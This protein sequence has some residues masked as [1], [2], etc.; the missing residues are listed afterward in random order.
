MDWSARVALCCLAIAFPTAALSGTGSQF[1]SL[2][3]GG[4]ATCG[5]AVNGKLYCWGTAEGGITGKARIPASP[6]IVQDMRFQSVSVGDY[7]ACGIETTGHAYCWGLAMPKSKLVRISDALTFRS[8]SSGDWFACGATTNGTAYCWT[9]CA[10]EGSITGEPICSDMAAIEPVRIDTPANVKFESVSSGRAD[11]ACGVASD[12]AGYCWG[13]RGRFWGMGSLR[14]GG[15]ISFRTISAGRY[16]AFAVS[17]DGT[18]YTWNYEDL[19]PR[20]LGTPVRF[21]TV[22]ARGYF[23]CATDVVGAGY[24][25]GENKDNSSY[26]GTGSNEA[27]KMPLRLFGSLKF[28]AVTTGHFHACGLTT[29]GGAYCW[30]RDSEVGNGIG[31]SWSIPTP[32]ALVGVKPFDEQESRFVRRADEQEEDE[33]WEKRRSAE[34]ELKMK[35][36][37]VMIEAKSGEQLVGAGAGILFFVGLDRAYVVTAYHLIRPEQKLAVAIN[38]RFWSRP[39]QPIEA[40]VTGDWDR[41]LDLVVLRVDG[42]DRLGL[43]LYSLPFGHVRFDPLQKGASL[44]HLGNPGG[45]TW[46][47]NVKPDDFLENRRGVAYFESN[48][49]RPGVSGGALLDQQMNLI[50]MIRADESGEGAAVS[51]DV[52]EGR[53]RTW[54]YPVYL[55][56]PPAAPSFSSVAVQNDTF[57]GV[58]PDHT[59][60]WWLQLDNSITSIDGLRLDRIASGDSGGLNL[61]G[62]GTGGEAHCWEHMD[63]GGWRQGLG[64]RKSVP[65]GKKFRSIAVGGGVCGL[66]SEDKA[67]CWTENLGDGSLRSNDEPVEVYGDL[68]FKSIAS[69]AAHTC[70]LDGEGVLYCW[71]GNWNGQLGQRPGVSLYTPSKVPGN[72][73]FQ[74]VSCGLDST[75]AIAEDGKAY[76][77]GGNEDGQLGNGTVV[78]S[79]APV[80]VVASAKL[81]SVSVGSD[82]ACAISADGVASCWG[83]NEYGQLG[84]NT[85]KNASTPVPVAGGLRFASVM[86]GNSRTI[87]ITTS[88]AIYTWGVEI[89]GGPD[90]EAQIARVPRAAPRGSDWASV[91]AV[92]AHRMDGDYDKAE[93]VAEEAF[94]K[95]PNATRAAYELARL[96]AEVGKSDRARAG[97]QRL[98]DLGEDRL[99]LLRISELELRL[100]DFDAMVHDLNRAEKLSTKDYEIEGVQIQRARA[101]EEM[102]EKKTAEMEY[103]KILAG[104]PQ[105]G[106]AMNNLAYLMA[107][108]NE[109]LQAAH[110]MARLAVSMESEA[111]YRLDTLGFVCYRMGRFAEARGYLEQALANGGMKDS[112]LLEHLGDTYSALGE[113]VAAA[114]MRRAAIQRLEAEP[115]KLRKSA[116]IERVRQKLAAAEH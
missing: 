4:T 3:A 33:K 68:R 36:L 96:M 112:D 13:T 88:G 62:L 23:T 69:G 80:E 105:S 75:C 108:E 32:V 74:S 79:A 19:A 30:G 35:R 95:Y 72:V 39:D 34:A 46:G 9:R 77:W 100:G 84:N 99:A 1:M 2:S 8:I 94:R 52:I 91:E 61:C 82:Y 109:Q 86:A 24:C 17:L 29:E 48:S 81:R 51:W 18:M 73:R 27:G 98:R 6:P 83:R 16:A 63:F 21:A 110:D 66:T 113:A 115:P 49:I 104:N 97:I 42:V 44:Y 92:F 78:K 56:L 25:W 40:K 45:R 12:G 116:V 53:L 50:G 41:S 106:L 101:H 58:A 37:I 85:T 71:G 55:G 28:S 15:K 64:D 43:D 87:G 102:G 114:A 76:C 107:E 70:G 47:G 59:V 57:W 7:I 5:V 60:Y 67:F 89:E 38:V 54:G 14:I 26:F 103:R 20:V 22:D 31:G 11:I 111:S 90:K 93:Q 65:G 10:R